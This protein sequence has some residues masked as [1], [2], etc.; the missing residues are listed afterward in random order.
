MYFS[1]KCYV[2]EHVPL[3][4]LTHSLPKIFIPS[5][6]TSFY[7]SKFKKRKKV[8]MILSSTYGFCHIHSYLS[9]FF[10][11]LKMNGEGRLDTKENL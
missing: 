9:F 10:E 2:K 8:R 3:K 11:V 5:F 4:L 6:F 1:V 7:F